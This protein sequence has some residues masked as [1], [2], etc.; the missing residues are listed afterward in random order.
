MMIVVK[1]TVC[2]I[3]FLVSW[4]TKV[5]IVEADHFNFVFIS[6]FIKTWSNVNGFLALAQDF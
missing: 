5:I 1:V 3:S 6:F 4:F 2:N